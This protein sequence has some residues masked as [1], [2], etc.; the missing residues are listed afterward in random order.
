[1]K[2]SNRTFTPIKDLLYTVYRIAGKFGENKVW[3]IFICT[4]NSEKK[5]GELV[6]VSHAARLN[7]ISF[8]DLREDE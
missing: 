7:W 8:V 6:D 3:Q 2:F 1:M 4:V 5:F